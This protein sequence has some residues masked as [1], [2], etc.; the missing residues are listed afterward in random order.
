M[1]SSAQKGPRAPESKDSGSPPQERSQTV[2]ARVGP[3]APTGVVED[4]QEASSKAADLETSPSREPSKTSKPAVKSIVAGRRRE[5]QVVT[6]T[7]YPFAQVVVMDQL[8]DPYSGLVVETIQEPL[9]QEEVDK[10]LD[11]ERKRLDKA[12]E[13]GPPVL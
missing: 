8:A 2:T 11:K 13:T 9:S 7:T 3:Q 10:A 1:A 6:E 5:A 4:S 12:G